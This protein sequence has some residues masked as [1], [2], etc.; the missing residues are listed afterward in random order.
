MVTYFK[1]YNFIRLKNT[2]VN[3][4]Q[5]RQYFGTPIVFCNGYRRVYL[6]G[7]GASS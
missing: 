4:V 5:N 6:K 3:P 7:D 2:M 1:V